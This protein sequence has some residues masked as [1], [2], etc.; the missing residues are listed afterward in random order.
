MAL[1][2]PETAVSIASSSLLPADVHRVMELQLNCLLWH[3]SCISVIWQNFSQ[4][5][6][7]Q[8]IIRMR[9][10][11]VNQVGVGNVLAVEVAKI[12]R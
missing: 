8:K 6:N 5:G 4:E 7:F 10:F 3:A 1:S 12:I 9:T 2:W 11:F